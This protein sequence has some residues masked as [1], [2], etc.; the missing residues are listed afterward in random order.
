MNSAVPEAHGLAS[1]DK[2]VSFIFRE[3][4]RLKKIRRRVIKGRYPRITLDFYTHLHATHTHAKDI[5]SFRILD[6]S[7]NFS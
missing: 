2:S 7:F 4:A 6:L 1:A 3:R 5:C